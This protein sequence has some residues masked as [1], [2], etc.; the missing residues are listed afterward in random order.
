MPHSK[1]VVT[2]VPVQTCDGIA[3]LQLSRAAVEEQPQWVFFSDGPLCDMKGASGSMVHEPVGVL[4]GCACAFEEQR[5]RNSHRHGSN[6]AV[7]RTIRSLMT[8][9]GAQ[10]R[11]IDGTAENEIPNSVF[12]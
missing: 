2:T 6:R 8:S 10:H 5:P 3:L 4:I 9:F 7:G 11:S 12:T 1:A